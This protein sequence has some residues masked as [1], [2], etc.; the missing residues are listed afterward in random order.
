MI[1][2]KSVV[3]PAPLRP[4]SP[5]NSPAR[6]LRSTLRRIPTG[7]IDTETRLSSSIGSVLPNYMSAHIYLIEDCIRRAIG[8]D[9]A[10]IK[11]NDAAGVTQDDVHVVLNEQD[12]HTG[13]GDRAHHQIH[14]AEFL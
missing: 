12:Q 7:P 1:V 5:A 10:I 4:I 3:L 13:I 9:T 14:N 2:R 6:K 11:G 8:D